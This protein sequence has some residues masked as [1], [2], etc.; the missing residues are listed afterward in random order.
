VD[1]LVPFLPTPLELL[2][3]NVI[4]RAGVNLYIKRDDLIHPTVSGNKWRKLKYN[5]ADAIVENN[6]TL[7]TFG[8]AYSN[9]LYATAAAGN[10]LGFKTIGIVR[11]EDFESKLTPTL[12][13]CKDQN[14]ALHFV[15]RQAYRKRHDPEYLQEISKKFSAPYIIPEGGTTELA[16]KG[17]GEMATETELQLG[18]KP[19]YYATAVGTGGTAAGILSTGNNVLAFSALKGGD[20]LADDVTLLLAN[21]TNTGRLKLLTEYH[22]GGYAKWTPELLTFISTFRDQHGIQLEQVYTAKMMFGLYDLMKKDFFQPGD[23]V[24]A[25]HTG[26]L[27]GLLPELHQ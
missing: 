11:G 16:L 14:M 22:F 24:V 15:S 4:Q 1:K 9:H 5:L 19:G 18:S 3:D 17:V 7:L 21:N 12:L 26:G 6:T 2:S 10:A 13:F 8:G 20:F 23:T 27:Q 25:V